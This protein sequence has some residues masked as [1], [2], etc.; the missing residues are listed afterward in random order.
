MP[1]ELRHCGGGS[2]ERRGSGDLKGEIVKAL[3]PTSSRL[4]AALIG[5]FIAQAIDLDS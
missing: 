4:R 5:R 1:R 2:D 3:L